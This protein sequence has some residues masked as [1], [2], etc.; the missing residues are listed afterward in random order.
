MN[1]KLICINDRWIGDK[2]AP[3]PF[4]SQ[5]VQAVRIHH[6]PDGVYYEL[7][8]FEDW[9]YETMAFARLRGPD[10]RKMK[11]ALKTKNKGVLLLF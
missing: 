4:F 1:T 7:Q 2:S 11:R 9:A 5:R 8:G 3:K 10:E 6:H